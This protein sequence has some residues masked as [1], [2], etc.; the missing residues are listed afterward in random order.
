MGL[1]DRRFWSELDYPLLGALLILAAF[2][3]IG[4]YSATI[5]AGSAHYHRQFIRLLMGLGVCLVFAAIDYRRMAGDF[6]FPLYFCALGLL[7][8][9]L[10]FGQEIKGSKSWI[11]LFGFTLQTSEVAKVAA[12]LA[13]ARFLSRVQGSL[14]K[15]RQAFGAGLV[16]AP[17]VLLV[18]LQG[19]AGTAL[20]YVPILGGMLLVAGLRIRYL[21]LTL[22]GL[23]LLAPLA[24][25][26]LADYQKERILVTFNPE[27]DPQGV[28][29]QTRQSKIAIGSGGLLGKGLGEGMQSQLGF[30]PEIQTDFIFALLA[31]EIGFIGAV[32]ILL[33]YLFVLFRLTQIGE[34]AQDRTGLLISAGVAALI[35][36]HVAT[37]V[38]MTLGL[39]PAIGVPLP[40]IS[41][42]GSSSLSMFAAIGLAL[43]VRMRRYLY[44]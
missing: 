11:V 30:V 8:A 22:L 41:W 23:A 4:V 12:I 33:L 10:I 28:G 40:F 27:L 16:I 18:L 17:S 15:S 31:E 36:G 44:R 13:T 5:E 34:S 14:L 43:N 19:D 39:L 9:T 37:N 21:L 2:G 6:A 20:M 26:S 3:I 38:G 1:I 24:W 35:F 25:L 29:Y 7:G 32:A 42:G